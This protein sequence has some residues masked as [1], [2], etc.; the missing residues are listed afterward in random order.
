MRPQCIIPI[1]IRC[2]RT[3]KFPAPE[4]DSDAE[5]ET[6]F[7]KNYV[8]PANASAQQSFKIIAIN[9]A[10]TA[11]FGELKVEQLQDLKDRVHLSID[12][13][14]EAAL[15]QHYNVKEAE[16]VDDAPSKAIAV[17]DKVQNSKITLT[18]CFDLFSAPEVL[19]EN[20][21]WCGVVVASAQH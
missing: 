6:A 16:R 12:W 7:T 21:K 19:G 15:Q 3:C 5:L 18:E 1:E 14:D 20:N 13:D 17:A 10:G 4:A 8:G 9:Q 11:S 2:R